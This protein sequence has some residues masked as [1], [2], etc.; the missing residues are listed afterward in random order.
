MASLSEAPTRSNR[1][2]TSSKI[3]FDIGGSVRQ[4]RRD[5]RTLHNPQQS[6]LS[7]SSLIFLILELDV[8]EPAKVN[9]DSDRCQ[10]SRRK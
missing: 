2:V 7:S 8:R 9:S 10:N 3:R 6:R 4:A 1:V 5:R